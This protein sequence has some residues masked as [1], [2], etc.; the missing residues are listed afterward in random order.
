M[1]KVDVEGY[2]G[3]VFESMTQLLQRHLVDN[4]LFELIPYI[5][6]AEESK[7]IVKL[8]HQYNYTLAESPFAF[9]EGVRNIDKPFIKKVIPMGEQQ[10][11]DMIADMHKMGNDEKSRNNWRAPKH[12][13]DMWATL[14][15]RLFED[16]NKVVIPG[17]RV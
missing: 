1:L 11:F 12:Y 9:L 15:P 13:T 16:Y 7:S 6:G 2:E 17:A 3:D 5:R 8:L 4:V 14:N 10:A